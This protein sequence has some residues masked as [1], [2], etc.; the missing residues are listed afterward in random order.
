M[1]KPATGYRHD[2]DG[3]SA[4]DSEDPWNHSTRSTRDKNSGLDQ[5]TCPGD[6]VHDGRYESITYTIG[7][8]AIRAEWDICGSILL[9]RSLKCGVPANRNGA[10]H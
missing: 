8:C 1:Q 3:D 6:E 5:V 4:M 2:A 10:G 9:P 7:G